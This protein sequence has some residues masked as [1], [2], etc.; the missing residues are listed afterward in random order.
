LLVLSA[1][2]AAAP[3]SPAAQGETCS[4][5]AFT[6]DG[7]A[8]SVRICGPAEPP[9]AP[10]GPKAADK[11]KRAAVTLR[12]TVSS[13]SNRFERTTTVDSIAGSESARTIDDIPLDKI[14][15]AKTLHVTIGYKPGSV[16][17]EHALLVP[18]AVP[19]K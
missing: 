8:V 19:L 14:G 4:D 10:D 15:I 9:K 6:I 18:G 13:G 17:L 11:G 5:D 1:A 7:H 16:R 2:L 12:E 3:A